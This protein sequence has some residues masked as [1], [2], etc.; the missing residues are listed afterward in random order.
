MP[1]N[2][3]VDVN[4]RSV[5][6]DAGEITIRYEQPEDLRDIA[7]LPVLRLSQLVIPEGHVSYRQEVAD[8]REVATALL[9]DVLEDYVDADTFEVVADRDDDDDD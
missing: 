8:L 7:G 1:V 6:W 9:V 4:V 3:L 5:I 2:P